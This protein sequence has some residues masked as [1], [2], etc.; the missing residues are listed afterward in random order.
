[1]SLE[2]RREALEGIGIGDYR[3]SGTLSQSG[4]VVFCTADLTMDINDQ[5]VKCV[6]GA[7]VDIAVTLPSVRLAAGRIYVI[8]LD[9]DGGKDI[10]ISDKG[11]DAAYSDVTLDTAADYVVLLSD[12]YTWR[13]LVGETA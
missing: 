4:K 7:S 9:T 6:T 2:N 11:G 1:M 12:G 8:V 5:M 13:L 3:V 10:V